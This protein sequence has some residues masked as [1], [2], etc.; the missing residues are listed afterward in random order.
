MWSLHLYPL[1]FVLVIFLGAFFKG[2]SSTSDQYRLVK[3]LF[4]NY[5]SEIRPVIDKSTVTTITL[6]FFVSKIL[7]MDEKQQ[8][9]KVNS[10]LTLE[11]FDEYMRWNTSDYGGL[12]Y[13]KIPSDKLWMPDIVLYDNADEKYEDYRKNQICVIYSNGFINWAAPVIFKSYCKIDVRRFPFDKQ[14]CPFK[15][16]P[17]QH[18]GTEVEVHGIGNNSVFRSDGQW[19]LV[20]LEVRNNVEF[21]PDSPGIPYTDATF[22]VHLN[23]RPFFYVFNLVMPCVLI[24]IF[25]MISFFLPADSGEKVSF[26]I[27]VLLSL[28]V[29]LLLVAESMP[30]TSDVPV[31]GQY[32]AATMIMVSF[33]VSMAILTLHVHHQGPNIRPIPRW[34][35][36]FVLGYL[37]R[38]LFMCRDKKIYKRHLRGSRS[39]ERVPIMEYTETC[40][41]LLSNQDMEDNGIVIQMNGPNENIKINNPSSMLH[42]SMTSSGNRQTFLYGRDQLKVLNQI[43]QQVRTL[44]DKLEERDKKIIWQNEWKE[45]AEVV[46]RLFLIL[47]ILG[48]VATMLIIAAQITF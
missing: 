44:T 31:I 4:T 30:P 39:R 28:T 16:G 20:E 6:R 24:S 23:R 46:D 48:T 7:E 34:V 15:Y 45:V 29:F 33:S 18:D 43:L 3:R 14:E 10:W 42:T 32:T 25:T 47:Y 21:Y 38:C 22:V 40:N 41:S 8:T 37:A 13:F 27:T 12:E 9:L 35:R 5:S 2:A 19:D 26:G 36:K 11:W 17:W 1:F